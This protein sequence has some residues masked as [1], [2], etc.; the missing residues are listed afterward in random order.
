MA[1]ERL[2][3]NL[4]NL[5]EVI[6]EE[7]RMAKKLAVDEMF[8]LTREKE[9]LLKRLQSLMNSAGEMTAAEKELAEAVD[10]ENLRNAYFFLSALQ[11]VRDT[12]GFVGDQGFPEAY[13][14][15]GSI[16]KKRFAGALLSG[17]V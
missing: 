9:R 4:N 7:R 11:W 1:E 17:R 16:V 14:E 13:E 6:L 8:A 3:D 10:S 15:S 12:M 2:L 5:H